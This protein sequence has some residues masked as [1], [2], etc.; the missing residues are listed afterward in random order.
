MTEIKSVSCA[1]LRSGAADAMRRI[2]PIYCAVMGVEQIGEAEW[3]K[4]L[5]LVENALDAARE[6]A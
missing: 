6:A 1:L 2:D 4:T 3:D 5:A